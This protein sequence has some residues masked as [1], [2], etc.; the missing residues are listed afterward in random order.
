MARDEVPG[1][2]HWAERA[3]RWF[4]LCWPGPVA[5]IGAVATSVIG[6]SGRRTG[7]VT[8]PVTINLVFMVGILCTVAAG[9]AS[10]FLNPRVVELEASE[11][12]ARAQA[13]AA[14][15]A[16]CK[17]LSALLAGLQQSAGIYRDTLRVSLY[18]AQRDHVYLVA[19]SSHNPELRHADRSALPK[20][21]GFIGRAWTKSSVVRSVLPQRR[22]AWVTALMRDGYTKSEAQA[23]SM[24]ARSIAAHRIDQQGTGGSVPLAVIVFE[25]LLP[26]AFDAGFLI[27]VQ[28]LPE[29]GSLLGALEGSR[30]VLP[31]VTAVAVRRFS[32]RL[33]GVF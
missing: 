25:S 20:T 11:Y 5:L 12:S 22:V 19:R 8:D 32:G 31:E 4:R 15:D 6:F 17:V 21:Q 24:R 26:R 23:L 7:L 9:V 27:S 33:P 29:W 10:L 16:T 3:V 14:F 13:N 30:D 18:V 1:S 28:G 2:V